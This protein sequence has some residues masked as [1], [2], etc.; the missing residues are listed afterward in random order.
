M[1]NWKHL[2]LLSAI[3]IAGADQFAAAGNEAPTKTFSLSIDGS[4]DAAVVAAC[5]VNTGQDVDVVTLKGQ[6]PQQREFSAFGVSC[7]IQKIGGSGR[8][9][10]Q[11]KRDGH[12]VSRSQS[13]GQGGVMSLSVQ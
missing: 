10:V 7:Q 6:V 4:G 13:S 1:T 11:M 12:L 8:I 3:G 2:A 5:L 9:D